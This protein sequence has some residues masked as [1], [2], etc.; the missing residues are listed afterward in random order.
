MRLVLGLNKKTF[1]A[2]LLLLKSLCYAM[3]GRGDKCPFG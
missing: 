2:A 1:Y 3:R